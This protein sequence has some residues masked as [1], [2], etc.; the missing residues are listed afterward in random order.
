MRVAVLGSTGFLGEQ[1][2]EV[3]SKEQG[4]QVT[5]LSGYRNVDKLIHQARVFRPRYLFSPYFHR[6]FETPEVET[7]RETEALREIL[8]SE[9]IEGVFF[10][11][12][13]IS[14]LELL[15]DLLDTQK[16]LWVASKEMVILAGGI[17]PRY[18]FQQRSNFIPL[19]SEH[20]AL[21]QMLQ[22]VKKEEVRKVYLTASGGPFYD[23][24]GKLADITPEMALSHPNW[25]M[26]TKITIDSANL[27]NK[28]LEVIE[29]A[30]IFGFD[31]QDIDV[32]VQRE[33]Y[34]H[35]LLELKNGFTLALLSPPDMKSVIFSALH[36]ERTFQ[37]PFHT[38]DFSRIC[39]L[40]FDYPVSPRFSG[41]YLALQAGKKASGYPALFC[42]ADETCVQAFL[43]RRITFDEIPL[44]IERVLE[45]V[46]PEPRNVEEIKEIYRL[47]MKTAEALITERSISG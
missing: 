24:Q 38:L 3:L 14:F 16:P 1:I 26:G 28:G 25:K 46:I 18:F 10:A 41:F 33:S 6:R 19:D 11:T 5:L 44:I 12:G 31:F 34:I 32:L 7:I 29:A 9:E 36:P 45:Q 39:S 42:G 37:N 8:L 27:I 4:Y 22:M 17:K 40:N 35:A 23:W 47:G 43:K 15:L 2:L 20:N 30:I 21:W 13:G